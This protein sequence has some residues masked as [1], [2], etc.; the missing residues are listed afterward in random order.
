[1]TGTG[2]VLKKPARAGGFP[3]LAVVAGVLGMGVGIG[4]G[5]AELG[6]DLSRAHDLCF[7]FC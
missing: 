5:C 7:F 1:M 2:K 6:L 4:I 3:F